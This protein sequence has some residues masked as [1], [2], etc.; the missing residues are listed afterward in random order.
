MIR[1]MKP[2]F[3]K[4]R[5]S[6][7]VRAVPASITFYTETLGFTVQTTMGDPPVFAVLVSD[8]ISLALVETAKPAVA[9]FACTYWN[10]EGV[11]E[12]HNRCVA[13]GAIISSQ[14]TRQP[15]GNYDFVV[16]DPDG[17][18]IALGEVPDA[19]H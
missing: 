7:G 2:R 3:I 17:H 10:I 11:E 14:L 16:C 19:D 9:S 13:A 1:S 8:G 15:W 5:S 18:Q 6:L 12:M 4:S